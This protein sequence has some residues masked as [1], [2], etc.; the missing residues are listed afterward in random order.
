MSDILM[1]PA[2]Q[3]AFVA[4]GLLIYAV[5]VALVATACGVVVG[6][7]GYLFFRKS[8]R[9]VVG[10][11]LPSFMTLSTI[12]VVFFVIYSTVCLWF[13]GPFAP[14]DERLLTPSQPV[15]EED[16]VGTWTLDAESLERMKEEG[17]YRISTH[18]LTFRDDGTF[19][20]ANM[21][22]WFGFAGTPTGGFWSGS[23]TWGMEEY[24]GKWRISVSY[25]TAQYEGGS[26]T[27]LH[28][29]G[30]EPPYYIWTYAGDPDAGRVMVFERQ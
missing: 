5:I 7:I 17:G 15:S 13:F 6:A 14:L 20:L 21:P 8:P 2:H 28:V 27:V 23:G 10:L 30:R 11:G 12:S 19:E 26:G 22:D 1:G 4:L 9:R 3:P 25:A 16:I 29:G 24:S 18:T